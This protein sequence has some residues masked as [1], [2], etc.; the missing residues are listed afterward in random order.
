LYQIRRS[1][2][3]QTLDITTL[4]SGGYA[5]T[6]AQDSFCQG[7]TCRITVIYDQTG[8]NNH[9]PVSGSGPQGSADSPAVA[10]ALPIVVSGHAVYGIYVVPGV[11]YRNTSAINTAR[12]GQAEGA[13]MV[14]SGTH[15]NA[16]CCFDYG[17]TEQPAVQDA[18]NGHMDAINFGTNCYFKPCSGNG[19]WVA[20]DMENGL[21]QG[22]GSNLNNQSIGYTFVTAMLKN[23][24]QT[25]FALKAGNA[26]TGPLTTKYQGSLPN[27]TFTRYMP[28]H[29]EGG[30]VLGLGG[31]NSKQ[32]AGSFFEGAMT[33][34]YP[35]D[36][37]EDAVQ[38]NIVA[39]G[40]GR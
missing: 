35:T 27:G 22:N 11:G 29:Q 37:A 2:D 38:K 31:D 36:A 30:I 9:L 20:A 18:G 14:T 15:V 12:N 24:G 34:G 17:N 4:Q 32:S 6:A 19:P 21:F 40:Y 3:S 33:S 5:D 1:S 10:D 23:N 8:N 16:G 26:Q 28:M 13:Y 7:T 25:T 39:A